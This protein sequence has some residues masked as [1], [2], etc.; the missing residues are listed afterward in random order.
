MG[1]RVL[2]K[3]I[4][5]DLSNLAGLRVALYCRASDDDSGTEKSVDDQEGVGRGWADRNGCV[6]VDV[7]KD[8]DRSA[9]RFATKDREDFER[10]MEDLR[11]GRIDVLWIWEVSRSQRMLRVY[12]DLRDLCRDRGI[13]WVVRD[14]VYDLNNYMDVATLGIFAVHGELEAEMTSERVQ[15]GMASSAA[16]GRPH[17]KTAYGYRRIY[18]QTTK[19]LLRQEPDEELRTAVAADGTESTYS[20]AG[21]VREIFRR[22]SEGDPLIIIEKD[23]NARGIPSPEGSVW[24]R[25]VIRKK[26][27]TVAY[28]GKRVHQGEVIGDGIWPA[29]IDEE[30]YWACVDSSKT[31]RGPRRSRPAPATCCPIWPGVGSV[32]GRCSA[33]R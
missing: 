22:V 10:L 15:R 33:R 30:T 11:A 16:K 5:R 2:N 17:G 27:M 23:L 28:I 14:R 24:V 3:K 29:L 7:Y 20:H 21:V 19:Q 9:S 18:D 25:L 32:V 26:A 8:N 31:R 1:K 13:P 6:V 12:A 4:R